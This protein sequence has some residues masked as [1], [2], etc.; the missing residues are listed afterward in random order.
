MYFWDATGVGL[1]SFFV[2]LGLVVRH[3]VEV[4][5]S[6]CVIGGDLAMVQ[7]GWGGGRD[8]QGALGLIY[9]GGRSVDPFATIFLKEEIKAFDLV[10]DVQVWT[11]KIE[12]KI[13]RISD[14]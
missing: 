1:Y 8:S 10:R 5:A 9:K 3:R 13:Q 2:D 11:K 12:M 7:Q 4:I 6:D 14:A